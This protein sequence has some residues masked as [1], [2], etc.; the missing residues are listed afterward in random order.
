MKAMWSAFAAV[1]AIA[2]IAGIVLGSLDYSAAER[3]A[4]D[5][6]RLE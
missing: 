4:T 1:A 5:S 6:V 3:Y 2:V